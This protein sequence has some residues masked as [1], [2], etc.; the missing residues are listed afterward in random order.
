[1]Y[2]NVNGSRASWLLGRKCGRTYE[3]TVAVYIQA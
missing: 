2:V 3:N 1:M